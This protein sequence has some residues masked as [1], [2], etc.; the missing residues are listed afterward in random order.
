MARSKKVSKKAT[1]KKSSARKTVKP[2]AKRMAARKGKVKTNAK[3]AKRG[4]LKVV[5]A[6]MGTLSQLER[7]LGKQEKTHAQLVK[8]LETKLKKAESAQNKANDKLNVFQQKSEGKDM[9]ASKL[10]PLQKAADTAQAAC[11]SAETEVAKAKHALCSVHHEL[12]VLKE[13][14]TALERLDKEEPKSN[15]TKLHKK[16]K[17]KKM[18]PAVQMDE[19]ESKNRAEAVRGNEESNQ[20]EAEDNAE[21]SKE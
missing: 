6:V 18:E 21:E 1:V 10:K 5:P 12:H 8:K 13:T 4:Q 17:H 16:G 3:S 2:A 19:I 15:V 20:E 9:P 7:E 14:R 11:A